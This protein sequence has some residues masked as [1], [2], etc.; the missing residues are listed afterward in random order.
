MDILSTTFCVVIARKSGKSWSPALHYMP[1]SPW[2]DAVLRMSVAHTT[3]CDVRA[4]RIAGAFT[5][6]RGVP[7][8]FMSDCLLLKV[9]KTRA[10][11]T[12]AVIYKRANEWMKLWVNSVVQSLRQEP[13]PLFDQKVHPRV[14]RVR[15]SSF[16]VEIGRLRRRWMRHSYIHSSHIAINEAERYAEFPGEIAIHPDLSRALPVCASPCQSEGARCGEG[17]GVCS[18][19]RGQPGSRIR[20]DGLCC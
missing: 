9:A 16:R 5:P 4:A 8:S 15:G 20:L 18:R 11:I 7:W 2:E 3:F 10:Q 6:D 17:R 12:G 1:N 13:L 14:R 19:N